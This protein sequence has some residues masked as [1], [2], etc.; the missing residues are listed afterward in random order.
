MDSIL[1]RSNSSRLCFLNTD[2]FVVIHIVLNKVDGINLNEK[3]II[4]KYLLSF[5]SF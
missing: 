5:T 1:Y 4:D 2:Y 3:S